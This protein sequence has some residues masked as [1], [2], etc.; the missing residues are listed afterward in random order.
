ML[1]GRGNWILLAISLLAAGTVY[2]MM[3]IRFTTPPVSKFELFDSTGKPITGTI[4]GTITAVPGQPLVLFARVRP[5]TITKSDFEGRSVHPVKSWIVAAEVFAKRSDADNVA[6]EYYGSFLRYLQEGEPV[7]EQAEGSVRTEFANDLMM[8]APVIVSREVVPGKPPIER[9]PT[10]E[11]YAAVV[12]FPKKPGSYY[13]RIWVGPT[14][15]LPDPNNP[16]KPRKWGRKVVCF[17]ATLV[18]AA[19]PSGKKT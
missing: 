14:A 15:D 2:W 10:A 5:G 4:T 6:T 7:R 16:G 17:E 9:L 19:E 11:L 13:L 12:P 8:G 1:N 3:K 18:V